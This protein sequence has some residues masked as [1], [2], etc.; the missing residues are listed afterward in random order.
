[1]GEIFARLQT[2]LAFLFVLGVLIFIH[3]LGHF[4]VAR[5]YGVRVLTF[6]LGFGPKLVRIRRGDT[7]Y[8]IS[9]VPLGGYVK[10]A[11]ET[12]QDTRSGEPDEFLSKS[13]WIRFQVYLAGP[14]MNLLLAWVVLGGVLTR[15][16]DIAA[17][18]ER[19][20]VVGSVVPDSPA[21]RA[22]FQAGDLI[23]RINDRATP[24]WD[25]MELVVMSK[26]NREIAVVASRGGVEVPIPIVPDAVG[27]F[28]IGHIGIA[29]L[30]RPQIVTVHPDTPAAAAGFQRGDV[31]L[32]VA[33]VRGLDHPSVLKK[34]RENAGRQIEFE[35]ERG[36]ERVIV[37]VTPA[38]REGEAT[39]GLTIAD[40][41]VRRV[42]LG[43]IDAF[44]L[45]AQRNWESTKMIGAM[46]RDLVTREQP[47][48]QLLGPVAIGQLAGGAA[49]L[50]WIPLFELMAMLSLNLGL[51]NLLPIPVL[52]GG[53]I[54][55][56]GIEGLFRRDLS[57]RVK[58]GIL[59]AGAAFIVLLM[60]TVIYN[61]VARLL[62]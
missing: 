26:A 6:S 19:A 60:V 11:G 59:I 7:E 25:S 42:D 47:V 32:G 46:L 43:F 21:A 22:G 51:L 17:Y 39:V 2:P 48:K 20:P 5:W 24:T 23:L 10:M 28:E 36:A 29:P 16:A 8:C 44:K 4:L 58:E 9:A 54:M 56:L 53:Q 33:G 41:E 37:P 12:V 13:K 14:V 31:I 30:L 3:E 49:Q 18:P 55:I 38:G 1:M 45:S 34:I 40:R 27:K 35:V 57:L 61:D 52:D 62:R 50:G 15:A